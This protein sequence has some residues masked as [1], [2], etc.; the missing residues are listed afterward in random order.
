MTETTPIDATMTTLEAL[1]Y[2]DLKSVRARIETLMEQKRHEAEADLER[3]RQQLV[4]EFDLAQAPKRKAP[5]RYR[6][7]DNSDNTWSGRGRQPQ[8]LTDKIEGGAS[9]EAFAV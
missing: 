6:D 9:L 1:T 2:K 4:L 5:V 8:W 3:R 7:P